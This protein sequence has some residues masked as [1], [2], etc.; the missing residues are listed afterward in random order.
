MPNEIVEV[1]ATNITIGGESEMTADNYVMEDD[2]NEFLFFDEPNPA[3]TESS[4]ESSSDED[5]DPEADEEEDKAAAAA[6][7]DEDKAAAAAA[8]AAAAEEED[9]AAVAAAE[10]EEDKA[11]ADEDKAAAAAVDEEEEEYFEIEYAPDEDIVVYEEELIPEDKVIANDQQQGDDLFNELVK[12]LPEKHRINDK[13][14][15]LQKK[16]LQN[17]LTLKHQF[18]LY[19]DN[20]EIVGEKTKGDNY[21][22]I[23]NSL[24]NYDNVMLYKPIVNE[25]KELYKREPE[26]GD[27]EDEIEDDDEGAIENGVKHQQYIDLRKKYTQGENRVNYSLFAELTEM[28]ALMDCYEA[29]KPGYNAT[30]KSDI[31]VFS[32]TYNGNTLATFGGKQ[33]KNNKHILVKGNV[34]SNVGYAKYP[35][36]HNFGNTLYDKKRLAEIVAD[37]VP[38]DK[39]LDEEIISSITSSLMI[40]D[41]VSVCLEQ[42]ISFTGEI[43]NIENDSYIIQPDDDTLPEQSVKLLK[44]DK[45]DNGVS[46]SRASQVSTSKCYSETIDAFSVFIYKNHSDKL[47]DTLNLIVPSSQEILANTANKTFRNI[48][49]FDTILNK[50]DLS[51]NDLTINNFNYIEDILNKNNSNTKHSVDL[52]KYEAD[53]NS[54]QK[55]NN[56]SLI[57]NRILD[58]LKE[59]YGPYPHFNNKLD[60]E[61]RRMRF[62]HG[63]ADHGYLF[64]KIII[65]NIETK[66]IGSKDRRIASI[67][68]YLDTIHDKKRNVESELNNQINR[69]ANTSCGAQR[70]TNIYYS[71]ADL[72]LDNDK[73]IYIDE[74]KIIPNEESDLVRDGYVAILVLGKKKVLYSRDGNRWITAPDDDDRVDE[75]LTNHRD[76]CNQNGIDFKNMPDNLLNFNN[77]K[78]SDK[79]QRCVSIEY[80]KLQEQLDNYDAIIKENET[81]LVLL[82]NSNIMIEQH[83][84]DIQS[85]KDNLEL[86][87]ANKLRLEKHFTRLYADIKIEVDEENAELYYKIDKY[88]EN[89]AELPLKEYYEG[90]EILINKYGRVASSLEADKENQRYIYCRRGQK[91]ICCEH[92]KYFIEFYNKSTTA[93]QMLD[94][95][96]TDYGIE[97]EGYVWCSN[98][99]QELDL[100]AYETLEGFTGSGSRAVTHNVIAEEEVYVSAEGSELVAS[101]K[102][103]LL[104]GDNKSIKDENSLSIIKII[105]VLLNF[106]GIKLTNADEIKIFKSCEILVQ[107]NIKAKNVWIADAIKRSKKNL[108]NKKLESLYSNYSTGHTILYTAS[109]LF[110]YIQSATPA[111]MVTKSHSKCKPSLLGYPLDKKYKYE[112]IDYITCI[113]DALKDTGSDWKALSIIKNV[114]DNLRKIIDM[115]AKGDIIK[116]RYNQCRTASKAADVAVADTVIYE[117]N[118]FKPPLATFDAPLDTY[119]KPRSRDLTL[120]DLTSREKLLTLS[121][122]AKI[123]EFINTSTVENIKFD[124]TPLDNSC[125]LESISNSEYLNYFSDKN[126]E[127]HTMLKTLHY[128][129]EQ[130]A[131]LK[132]AENPRQIF[133]KTEQRPIS[134]TFKRDMEIP[135]DDITDEEIRKLF[136]IFIADGVYTGDKYMF[137]ENDICQLTGKNRLVILEEQH[138]V[139]E[140]EDL[141]TVIKRKNYW[142]IN[143]TKFHPNKDMLGVLLENNAIL[144]NDIYLVGISNSK[145]DEDED[146]DALVDDLKGQINAETDEIIKS[147][148]EHTKVDESKMEDILMSLGDTDRLREANQQQYGVKIADEMQYTKKTELIKSYIKNTLNRTLLRIR[149]KY[150]NS[151]TSIVEVP[152]NWKVDSSVEEHV[153]KILATDNSILEHTVGLDV[154]DAINILKATTKYI[155]KLK[156]GKLNSYILHYIFVL[157]IAK[158]TEDEVSKITDAEVTKIDV[159]EDADSDDDDD[160]DYNLT[161]NMPSEQT[162]VLNLI[163]EIITKVGV[164][165]KFSDKYTE[166][167]IRDKIAQ[168]MENDKESNLRFIQDLDR[169]TWSSLKNMISLGLDTWKNLSSKSMDVYGSSI[170]TGGAAAAADEQDADLHLKATNDL[171]AGFTNDQFNAWRENYDKNQSE[172]QLAYDERDIMA[173][174][175]DE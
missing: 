140:Y 2:D 119:G 103:M 159:S 38:I 126:D 49:Q 175:D 8:A 146:E 35:D 21:K 162:G 43:V 31:E 64:Y 124:P 68:K 98:C 11:A 4:D 111:Y 28:Y 23:L 158:I 118:E 9:K 45:N 44:L 65:H 131:E 155:N 74:D 10:E 76:F 69:N 55:R 50:Y 91:V 17:Y 173:D 96:R 116:H 84:K 169:E 107:N 142:T 172:D 117:W 152:V 39:K 161:E 87:Y 151:Q 115:L 62:V 13:L 125:C 108:T 110:V 120:A 105:D 165:N 86:E 72:L 85:L 156:A 174:D 70:L 79:L 47:I 164:E 90:L 134:T 135:A 57:S 16:I 168:K 58:S 29:K 27:D 40:G 101:L 114:K 41:K 94:K 33:A 104:E 136:S 99:G 78:Y 166:N 5:I 3:V 170:I 19:D 77:C 34:I 147:L 25:T 130:K 112:G 128:I 154:S 52:K 60:S 145:T 121:L 37:N 63:Q 123:N 24:V 129:Y 73:T 133:L 139:E 83:N 15:G 80:I 14:I 12:M 148:K 102:H 122:M 153:S 30:L 51:V 71:K 93:E 138:T 42:Q 7:E 149:N 75:I 20:N 127:I 157:I 1:I 46:I 167:Y 132:E 61:E 26:E 95:L 22:P 106:M 113:L 92:H 163:V 97:N 67:E 56:Y 89:I 100:A 109:N 48:S 36:N 54:I 141:K 53:S 81:N 137:D 171:G 88:Q 66:L 150:R 59:F 82:R 6:E 144:R 32:N 143:S 160:L 18:S